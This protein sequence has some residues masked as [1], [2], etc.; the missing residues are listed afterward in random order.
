MIG[1]TISHY[2]VLE[3]LGEGG[4]SQ[5]FPR[6]SRQVGIG[7]VAANLRI[8]LKR[9]GCGMRDGRSL[10]GERK[11]EKKNETFLDTVKDDEDLP[12]INDAREKLTALKQQ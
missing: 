3:K 6:S 8:P 1:Q 10:A 9:S 4:M 11:N 12:E 5:T 7:R 2:K